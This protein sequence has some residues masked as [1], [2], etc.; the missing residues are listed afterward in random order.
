MLFLIVHAIYCGDSLHPV[1]LA[2]E[3]IST[4]LVC[5]GSRLQASYL[6]S[7]VVLS[8]MQT[9]QMDQVNQIAAMILYSLR[10]FISYLIFLFIY[11]V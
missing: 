7:C 1:I 11:K 9:L 5:C 6:R 4:P 10:F 3:I 8:S 2:L